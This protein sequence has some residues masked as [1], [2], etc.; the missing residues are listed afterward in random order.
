MKQK[1]ILFIYD[2]RLLPPRHIESIIGETKFSEIVFKKNKLKNTVFE[3]IRDFE[4]IFFQNL[5]DQED[6][7]QLVK[8]IKNGET[9]NFSIIYFKSY[10]GIRSKEE[11]QFFLKKTLLSQLSLFDREY[12]PLFSFFDSPDLCAKF[13]NLLSFSENGFNIYDLDPNAIKIAEQELLIDL[14]NF[15]NFISFFSGSLETRYFNRIKTDSLFLTKESDDRQKIEKE[16]R[17]YHLL[18][19]FMKFWFVMPF[20][21]KINDQTASYQMERYQIPDMAV[22]WIHFGINNNDFKLF[23]DKAFIFLNQRTKKSISSHEVEQVV[24]DLFYTKVQ[25]R[26]ESFKKIPIYENLNSYIKT[27]TSYNCIEEIFDHYFT[28]FKQNSNKFQGLPLVVGH[29]DFCFSNILYDKTTG[30]MRLIDPKGALS[31]DEIW[32]HPFYDL[33]KLSHSILGN[34]DFINNAQFDLT[35][36][37]QCNIKLQIDNE[38]CFQQQK[39]FLAKLIQNDIDPRIIRLGEVSLFLSMLPLHIDYPKKVLAFLLN[40]IKILKELEDNER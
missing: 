11:F 15:N 19:D 21:L 14:C 32:S 28:L 27:G 38:K 25:N 17:Y 5:K 8:Q 1:K 33:V 29:G 37:D 39:N 10:A 9:K 3:Y 4:N 36:E 35:L 13:I 24:C 2:D 7:T 20:N 30:L 16:Y 12:N 40:S 34:Y 22:Q 26:F 18:D 23:I 31:Q 6:Y